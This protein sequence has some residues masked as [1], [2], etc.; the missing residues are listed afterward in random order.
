MRSLIQEWS[1]RH[2]GELYFEYSNVV[3][4]AYKAEAEENFKET[5]ELK[6]FEIKELKDQIRDLKRQLKKYETA[7]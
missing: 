6:D 2:G 4:D 1:K 5:T 3:K 7:V